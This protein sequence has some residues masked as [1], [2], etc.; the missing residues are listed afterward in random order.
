MID[1]FRKCIA[2]SGK[3]RSLHKYCTED[4]R[5]PGEYDDLL[6]MSVVY[7]MSALDRLIHDIVIMKMV[8][9][10]AGR[11]QP[12]AKYL[13]E[14]I[15]LADHGNL[16]RSSIPPPEIAFEGI[17]RRKLAHLSF[18]DPAKMAD[19]LSLVWIEEHKWQAIADAVGRD[20]LQV[21]TEL[22]NI[23]QRRNA[24]VHET[25]KDPVTNQKFPLLPNDAERIEKFV[26]DLG[27]AI[28]ELV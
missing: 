15:S 27:E 6:R 14:G 18:M 19:A 2:D 25:D 4:L 16:V 13:A 24:I 21:R 20:Q 17:V 7:C 9:I 26:S 23:F 1:E 10:F 8:D 5:L 22:R 12:T 11:R 28:C 3:L